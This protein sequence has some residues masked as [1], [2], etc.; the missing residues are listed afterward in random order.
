M[1]SRPRVLLA[2]D[3]RLVLEGLQRILEPEFEVVGQVEDGRTLLNLAQRLH[4]EV[5]LLDVSMPLLN[6]IDAARQIARVCPGIK[7][8]MVTMHSDPR[9]VIE[10]F[11]AGAS[12]FVLKRSRPQELIHAIWTVLRGRPYVAPELGIDAAGILE[13]VSRPDKT[14]MPALTPREREVLQLVAEGRSSKDIAA[15][16][17]ISLK[18][19]E[20][21][22]SK[23][24]KRL[25]MKKTSELT[26][27]ALDHGLVAQ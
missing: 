1:K 22:R 19:V 4:P 15:L 21:H 11:R 26:R 7:L 23:I 17:G 13:K 24:R 18:A 25:G 8:M 10:A 12:G 14:N 20:F 2:D 9:Y 27:Y 6:G 5:I 16:L 3:H